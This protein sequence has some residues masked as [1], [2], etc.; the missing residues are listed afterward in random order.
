MILMYIYNEILYILVDWYCSKYSVM[1]IYMIPHTLEYWAT[2]TH[3]HNHD[4]VMMS[5]I[6]SWSCYENPQDS[7]YRRSRLQRGFKIC[8]CFRLHRRF[9]IGTV[10]YSMNLQPAVWSAALI[11]I[12][13]VGYPRDR[14]IIFF[15]LS[16]ITTIYNSR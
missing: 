4:R 3:D 11:Q 13:A 16:K 15:F 12:A 2:I 1:G 7:S 5:Y 8:R 14:N 10:G 6:N 9:E